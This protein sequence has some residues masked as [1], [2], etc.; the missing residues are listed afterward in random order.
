MKKVLKSALFTITK[1]RCF[2]EVMDNCAS[3]KREGQ[4]GT[5][6]TTDM[7][8]AYQ[9]L[10]KLGCAHSFEI[11]FQNELVGGLY[12]VETGSVFCGESMFSLMSN[13]S[14]T[15]LIYLCQNGNYTLIDCQLYTPHLESMGARLISRQEYM[16]AIAEP[17]N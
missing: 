2:A 13:A 12:G 4:D 8:A 3:A 15:A 5:W 6:I 11:W 14:K 7:K 16:K 1:N 17:Y 9:D 10:H